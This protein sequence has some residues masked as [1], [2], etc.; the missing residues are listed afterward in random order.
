MNSHALDAKLANI[1]ESLKY[2]ITEIKKN[3]E[4]FKVKIHEDLAQF[5]ATTKSVEESQQHISDDYDEQE[6]KINQLIDDNKHLQIENKSLNSRINNMH[7]IIT[8]NKIQINQHSQYVRSSWRI[9]LTG[10]PT[11]KNENVLI[12]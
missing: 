11:M 3:F 4:I 8:H 12:I 7:E 1:E 6:Q 2:D 10:I 9:E 5:K